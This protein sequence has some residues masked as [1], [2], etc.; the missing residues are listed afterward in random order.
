MSKVKKAFFC[1]NCGAQYAKWQGQC[2]SC[3]EWNTI[4]EEI[5]EKENKET[6]IDW[7]PEESYADKHRRGGR[8][9]EKG[10]GY[11]RELP[12]KWQKMI[13]LRIRAMVLADDRLFVAEKTWSW[14]P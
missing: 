8:G 14:A 5:I 9:V 7:L 11:V 4:A 13:P 12:A 6:I 1:Q 10:T 3:G 2:S